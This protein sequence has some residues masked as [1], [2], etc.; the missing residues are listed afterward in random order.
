MVRRTCPKFVSPSRLT[1]VYRKVVV[2][3]Q[4][5][6]SPTSRRPMKAV[7]RGAFSQR[8]PL[9]VFVFPAVSAEAVATK[10]QTR[11]PISPAGMHGFDFPCHGSINSLVQPCIELISPLFRRQTPH[12]CS[13]KYPSPS[14]VGKELSS[15]YIKEECVRTRAPNIYTP[16]PL[17]S[18]HHFRS[19]VQNK[20]TEL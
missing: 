14:M 7:G 13:I 1:C 19:H 11:D 10:D 6:G 17:V 9:F 3:I 8:G 5:S 4:A 2:G 18:V 16:S 20:T 15:F 12:T